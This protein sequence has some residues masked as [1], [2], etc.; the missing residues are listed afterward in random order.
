MRQRCVSYQM[1]YQ[2]GHASLRASLPAPLCRST[3]LKRSFWYQDWPYKT[4]FAP[5]KTIFLIEFQY[6]SSVRSPVLNGFIYIVD[7]G[8]GSLWERYSA[9]T[10][11][12]GVHSHKNIERDLSPAQ[13]EHFLGWG[14]LFELERI[15]YLPVFLHFHHNPSATIRLVQR[16]VEPSDWR[17]AVISP[18]PFGVR[19]MDQAH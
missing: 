3:P 13:A 4:T 10:V 12:A 17:L 9:S 15:D 1:G 8:F 6:I 2:G 11:V 16:F 18:L 19:V 7:F 14:L 5:C